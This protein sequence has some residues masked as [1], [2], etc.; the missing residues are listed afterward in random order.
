MLEAF[1]HSLSEPTARKQRE[2]AEKWQGVHAFSS[3]QRGGREMPRLARH[4]FAKRKWRSVAHV[5]E[6]P[7][8][9]EGLLAK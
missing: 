1:S 2:M 6:N 3:P 4:S 5:S 9:K 7:L 8:V